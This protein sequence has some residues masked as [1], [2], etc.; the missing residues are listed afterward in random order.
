M[1]LRKSLLH[2]AL[3]GAIVLG[4]SATA[5]GSSEDGGGNACREAA[6]AAAERHD[7][8][9]GLLSAIAEVESDQN[10]LAIN[11]AGRTHLTDSYDDAVSLLFNANGQPRRNV[12]IG[13]MQIHTRWHLE[14]VDGEPARLLSPEENADV[15][16]TI[17]RDL[18]DLHGT[19]RQAV[20]RYNGASHGARFTRYVCAVN[21]E[22]EEAGAALDLGC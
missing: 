2:V 10:A 18:H 16:A 20:G 1:L 12:M 8:P 4:T 5:F 14:R 6:R 13:C 7:I 9:P 17:L 19:W 3:I 22:L 15:A 11:I 21:R